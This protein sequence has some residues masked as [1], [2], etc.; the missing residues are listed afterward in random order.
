[1]PF[2][3]KP[4]L[5][6]AGELP[7]AK[8]AKQVFFVRQ[9]RAVRA[10][11]THF[12]RQS[13]VNTKPNGKKGD[14][15]SG[16]FRFATGNLCC[17]T[18]AAVQTTRLR[19]KQVW[20]D[21]PPPSALLGPAST[22]WG[23]KS[24]ADAGILSVIPDLIRDPSPLRS[25]WIADQVRNDKPQRAALAPIFAFIPP[26]P[27]RGAEKRRARRSALKPVESRASGSGP[28][29]GP[30]ASPRRQDLMTEGVKD[31]LNNSNA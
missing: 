6:P 26:N 4:G 13:Y 29:T 19:L 21:L 23:V 30:T 28:L 24:G 20:P 3:T 22:G 12:A 27:W 18:P 1:M 10:G 17:S 14:P 16:S 5:A 25:L 15:P 31:A 9:R 11:F 2:T 7:L 8:P